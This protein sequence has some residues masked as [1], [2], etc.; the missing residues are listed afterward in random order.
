MVR[1]EGIDMVFRKK[2]PQRLSNGMFIGWLRAL[3]SRENFALNE[4]SIQFPRMV[5]RPSTMS[6]RLSSGILWELVWRFVGEI[7]TNNT[8]HASISSL[9]CI[10]GSS[11]RPTTISAVENLTSD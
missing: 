1:R 9:N 4:T 6:G 10:P 5:V 8:P 3:C 11:G 7:Q 2:P